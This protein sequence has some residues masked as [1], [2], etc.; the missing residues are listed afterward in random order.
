MNESW[1]KLNFYSLWP[2]L[3]DQKDDI[4]DWID[5]ENAHKDYDCETLYS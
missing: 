3:L 1:A 4:L 2:R 5:G